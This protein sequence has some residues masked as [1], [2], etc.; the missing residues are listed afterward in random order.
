MP[1]LDARASVS[2]NWNR[3]GVLPV[4]DLRQCKTSTTTSVPRVVAALLNLWA[5]E[6]EAGAAG[7]SDVGDSPESAVGGLG[8]DGTA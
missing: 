8:D 6:A 1:T 4:A 7:V 2:R 5:E 3:I